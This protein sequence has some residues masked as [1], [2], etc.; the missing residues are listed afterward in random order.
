MKKLGMKRNSWKNLDMIQI[1]LKENNSEVIV[2]INSP[3][4][5]RSKIGSLQK[6]NSKYTVINYLE[7][8]WNFI[9]LK[10]YKKASKELEKILEKFPLTNSILF[11][12]FVVSIFLKEDAFPHLKEC[13]LRKNNNLYDEEY[14]LYLE[15]Y[16]NMDEDV[17]NLFD[18]LSEEKEIIAFNK[19]S[20]NGNYLELRKAIKEKDFKLAKKKL[21]ICRK[22]RPE[23]FHLE[24]L[25][26]L[27]ILVQNKEEELIKRKKQQERELEKERCQKLI[28]LIKEKNFKEAKEQV[29]LILTYRSSNKSNHS[30]HLIL[31]ILEIVFTFEKDMT[32]ELPQ[33]S[34]SYQEG[35]DFLS[36]FL[37][38]I[39]IGDFKTALEVGKKCRNKV[40]D[41]S[42]PRIKVGTYLI[43]LEYLVSSLE[44]RMKEQDNLYKIVQNNIQKGHF[45][46]AL[47]LY[48]NNQ[49]ILNHYQSELLMDLFQSGIAIEKQ[50]VPFANIYYGGFQVEAKKVEQISIEDIQQIEENPD[51]IDEDFKQTKLTNEMILEEKDQESSPKED[52]SSKEN[53]LEEGKEEIFY[54]VEP[55][56]VHIE[57]TQEY[58]VYFTKCLEFGQYE[59]AKYWLTQ[60]GGLLKSNQLQKR[61]DHYYYMAEVAYAESMEDKNLFTKKQELYQL[62]YSA[63]RNYDYNRAITYL[64]YYEKMDACR[65][66][67]ALILKGYIYRKMGRY[68]TA[69]KYFIQANSISPNP[70]AYYF[71]GDIYY[72]LHRFKDAVFCYITYN[73]FYPKENISV[74]LNLS[75][76]YRK[77]NNANK[78]LK[79]LRIADEINTNQNR[80][81][82]LKNRIL[83]TELANHKKERFRLK[84]E[85]K[86]N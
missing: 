73:E 45:I 78:S 56:L 59:E 72:K 22:L 1:K 76:C 39:S 32:F 29:E 8:V 2:F 18:S 25:E 36:T 62:A 75:E 13:I 50:E 83:R 6:D 80:G 84:K 67:K 35:N 61:L 24:I 79:Y 57:P 33:V 71:L 81:L 63:M 49:I 52:P 37:E 53:V 14:R 47:E 31:E 86:V 38:S 77:L 48:Q 70:D 41:A 27:L 68:E 7:K 26:Q 44:A 64:E 28:S 43:V 21:S 16:R 4:F 58:F 46:H 23:Y 11:A 9:F 19:K 34:Y 5:F 69:M 30:Y 20:F 12:K 3:A 40:L 65:N 17:D 60:Y 66:N 85:E 51:L 55:L 54:T 74:Y 42:D 82:N 15:L 10:N